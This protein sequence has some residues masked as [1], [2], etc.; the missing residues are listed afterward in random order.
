MASGLMPEASLLA[1]S[2]Q[3]TGLVQFVT[4]LRKRRGKESKAAN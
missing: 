2:S 4:S 1:I 3:S